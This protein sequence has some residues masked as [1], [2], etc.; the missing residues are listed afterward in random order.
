[1]A[2]HRK[3]PPDDEVRRILDTGITY[4]AAARLWGVSVETIKR[5]C[6]LNKYRRLPPRVPTN[7]PFTVGAEWKNAIELLMIRLE[8][9]R[10][11]GVDLKPSDNSKLD[12]WL[13]ALAKHNKVVAFD[14]GRG[15]YYVP[16]LPTDS[17]IVRT[18]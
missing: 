5:W 10:A 9:K 6:R 15:F 1:M 12:D 18:P 17:G 16:R 14:R 11:A 8:A 7:L 13:G 3:L 4:E 2:N